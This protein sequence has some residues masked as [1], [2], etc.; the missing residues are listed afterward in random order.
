MKIINISKGKKTII[1]NVFLRIMPKY[2]L[3][4]QQKLQSILNK[5]KVIN[6]DLCSLPAS[7]INIQVW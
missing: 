3:P 4:Q 5:Y 7:E 1:T 2:Y 6:C